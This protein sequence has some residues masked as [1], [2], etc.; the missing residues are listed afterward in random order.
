M[1]RKDVLE[2]TKYLMKDVTDK[3]NFVEIRRQMGCDYRTAKTFG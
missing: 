3:P 1:Y 2:R